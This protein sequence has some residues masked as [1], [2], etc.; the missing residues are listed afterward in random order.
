MQLLTQLQRT[1]STQNEQ[2]F[3][4]EGRVRELEAMMRNED[5]QPETPFAGGP[6]HEFNQTDI[7]PKTNLIRKGK[8]KGFFFF[9]HFINP[10]NY[11]DI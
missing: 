8:S 9:L 4:L 5:N 3:Q 2:I 11:L 7:T 1:I 6:S 10:Y